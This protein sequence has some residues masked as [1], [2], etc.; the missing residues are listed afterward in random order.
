MVKIAAV[1]TLDLLEMTLENR[2]S[3]GQ[4]SGE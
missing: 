3:D 1:M 2:P 4:Q